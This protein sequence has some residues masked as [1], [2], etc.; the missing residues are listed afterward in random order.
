MRW[1][2]WKDYDE[3]GDKQNGIKVYPGGSRPEKGGVLLSA[4]C[5]LP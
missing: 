2:R 4:E 5:A 1:L 3:P